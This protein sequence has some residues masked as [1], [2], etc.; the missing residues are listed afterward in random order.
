[1]VRTP[2]R[3]G[4]SGHT[5]ML[6][7]FAIVCTDRPCREGQTLCCRDIGRSSLFMGVFGTG[8]Y[9]AEKAGFCHKRTEASGMRRL[10]GT[11]KGTRPPYRAFAGSDGG[12]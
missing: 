1:M 6:E 10:C 5:F 3:K 9:D 12:S 11:L 8:M 4:R 2:C 7:V